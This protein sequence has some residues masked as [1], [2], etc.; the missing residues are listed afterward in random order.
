MSAGDQCDVP[1][2]EHV[3]VCLSEQDLLS[4]GPLAASEE[5]FEVRKGVE[6][7]SWRGDDLEPSGGVARHIQLPG[8]FR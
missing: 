1:A 7:T 3:S 2:S 6:K 4:W 8:G 5:S